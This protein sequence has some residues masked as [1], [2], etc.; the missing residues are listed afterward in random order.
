[1]FYKNS[2]CHSRLLVDICREVRE[3]NKKWNCLVWYSLFRKHQ[4]RRSGH[5]YTRISMNSGFTH[6]SSSYSSYLSV[7]FQCFSWL[8]H[9]HYRI[10]KQ[11]QHTEDQCT[12]N[13]AW[14][15][16]KELYQLLRKLWNKWF[17]KVNIKR[18]HKSEK[19]IVNILNIR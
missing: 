11:W 3:A 6:L 5:C 16:S 12:Q 14:K 8:F 10:E 13:F 4:P 18:T 1:M 15:T 2:A 17:I 19:N 7:F 9:I